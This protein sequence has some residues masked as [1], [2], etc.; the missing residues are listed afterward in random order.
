V[1][2]WQA[3]AEQVVPVGHVLAQAPQLLGSEV[4]LMHDEPHAEVPVG[5]THAPPTHDAPEGHTRP[6]APQFEALVMVFT[7]DEPHCVSAPQPVAQ[8]PFEQTCPD[9]HA[10]PHN[11]QFAG[12]ASLSTQLVPQTD[13]PLGQVH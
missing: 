10:L 9:A 13:V 6:Q 1:P 4:V 11:P 12:S 3:P 7:H 2:H 5:Q 8:I